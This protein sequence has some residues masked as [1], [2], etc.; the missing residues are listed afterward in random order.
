MLRR[1]L[2]SRFAPFLLLGTVALAFPLIALAQSVGRASGDFPNLRA[3]KSET[4]FG[5]LVADALLTRS[6][7]DCAL[8]NAGSLKSGTL[9]E[10]PIENSDLEALLSFSDDDVATLSLSGAQLKAALERAASVFPTGSPAFLQ[11]AGVKARF[12]SKQAPGKRVSA[13]SVRGKQLDD[14]ATYS[15]AMPSSL[16]EGAAGFF[17]IW[18]GAQKRSTGASLM[19]DLTAYIS[20]KGDISPDTQPRFD[21][22]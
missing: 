1:S 22:S 11:V 12:D 21:G 5:R 3:N 14:G 4:S 18:N 19:Q 15:V 6:G 9:G 20:S 8:I 7:A 16:A 13:V 17:N 10:G 2:F